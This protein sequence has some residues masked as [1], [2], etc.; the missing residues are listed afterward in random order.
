MSPITLSYV[1]FISLA[2]LFNINKRVLFT[3]KCLPQI[4][5]MNRVFNCEEYLAGRSLRSRS[6][7]VGNI[8][9]A[10]IPG[11]RLHLRYGNEGNA[12]RK[13]W[14][15]SSLATRERAVTLR[16]T[17]VDWRRIGFPRAQSGDR[18]R[19]HGKSLSRLQ[20]SSWQ[21]TAS[22]SWREHDPV[23]ICTYI[24]NRSRSTDMRDQV[25]IEKIHEGVTTGGTRD[26]QN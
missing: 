23:Y 4:L 5:T 26:P 9:G 7:A 19:G 13:S 24:S 25:S 3:K 15:L 14:L 12:W 1:R 2:W 6:V 21:G 20:T 22:G 8:P 17:R 16:R 18:G 11:N 10:L